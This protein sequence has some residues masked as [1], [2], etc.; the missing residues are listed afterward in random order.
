MG[1]KSG[2]FAERKVWMASCAETSTC[3]QSLL[4]PV[5]FDSTILNQCSHEKL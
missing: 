4:L 1:K 2:S 5:V 3:Q